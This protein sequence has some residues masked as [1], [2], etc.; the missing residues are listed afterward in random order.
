KVWQS[1]VN[2]HVDISY[3]GC[4]R[5]SFGMSLEMAKLDNK[6]KLPK[7]IE[8]IKSILQREDKAKKVKIDKIFIGKE[9]E[10]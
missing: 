4:T 8:K 6:T 7:Y 5:R 10:V 2:L 3:E 9:I 1:G